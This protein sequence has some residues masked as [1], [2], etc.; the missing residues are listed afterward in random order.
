VVA[1]GGNAQATVTWDIVPG[2]TT[3]N[4]WRAT[5][6]GGPYTLIAGNIGGV[7]L[8]YVDNT[9]TNLT[10]YYYVVTA[11]GNGTG[12]NSAEVSATPAAIVASVTATATNGQIVVSWI[13]MPGASYNLKR[14]YVSGG[15]YATIASSL[16]ATN[17]TD[18][19]VATCQNYYYVVTI[20]NAGNESLNS[21][22]ASAE[23]PGPLPPQFTSADIG[24][25]GLP[26]SASF[27]GGQYTISGSGADIWNNADAFQFVYTYVPISTNCDIRAR[28]A[29]V[30]NT[31]GNAKAALMIRETL[32]PGS[33]HALVDVEP[34]A[35]IEFLFRTNTAGSSY[36][37]A[38]ANQTAPNWIRLTRTNNLFRAYWSPDGNTWSQIGTA[39]NI[40]MA[41]TSAYIG[42][43]VCAHN[44]IALNTST[45]DNL[46]ASFLTNI[47]P[48]INWIVPTNNA[49]FIQPTTIT[50]TALATDADG[51]VTNVA[52][53]NGTHLLGT[54]ATG[55]AGEFS[56]VWSN[57]A[58]ASYNLTAVATDNSGAT[59][60]S[61]TSIGIVVK[62]LTMQVSGT[63]VGGQFNL[64][65]QGQN[66]QNYVVESSTNLTSWIPVWTN[67]PTNGVL[68]FTD[69]NAIGL[70]RFYRVKVGPPPP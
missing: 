23:V 48:V 63:Q 38:V 70:D 6:H 39:T 35:G 11:N 46:T 57:V 50:L 36:S 67:A 22:E 58:P 2:A 45:L 1:V 49:T 55:F 61:P 34:T 8:G 64:S 5:T 15:P 37:V 42:L 13:G 14:S 47:P 3:Y 25:V 69:T 17:F 51:L 31:S 43:A 53:F 68:Q 41:G 9:V 18:A 16:I 60:T 19:S 32:D 7:N 12:A 65:F 28:V 24:A 59:N 66:G 40:P 29:S 10:T 20:T 4:L 52:F 30:Q 62:P 44:N 54:L 26:G 27:C 33:R 21:P 56:L